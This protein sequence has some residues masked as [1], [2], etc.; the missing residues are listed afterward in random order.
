MH[1][2]SPVL[3]AVHKHHA[4]RMV[5]DALCMHIHLPG[6]CTTLPSYSW[7]PCAC[8]HPSPQLPAFI[9][10]PTM[11]LNE[12]GLV[13]QVEVCIELNLYKSKTCM[14][15]TSHVTES[16]PGTT[17]GSYARACGPWAAGSKKRALGLRAQPRWNL[18][19]QVP[20]LAGYWHG[21][22]AHGAGC[23]ER[24]WRACCWWHYGGTCTSRLA[25]RWALGLVCRRP[26]FTVRSGASGLP[27]TTRFAQVPG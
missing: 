12:R 5:S 17:T 15:R 19:A 16:P 4:A 2:C 1:A 24:R 3:S 9:V 26:L 23:G 22:G 20:V 18:R 13:M 10:K 27:N 21:P 14:T 7:M 25:L 8:W 11:R 6:T